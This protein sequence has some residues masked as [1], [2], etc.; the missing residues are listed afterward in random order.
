MTSAWSSK[1]TL[2]KWQPAAR[3]IWTRSV[4]WSFPPFSRTRNSWR[5]LSPVAAPPLATIA[6]P[7]MG[8]ARKA[9]SDTPTSMTMTVIWGGTLEDIHVTL[10]HGIRWEADDDTRFNA[11]PRYLADGILTRD[12]VNDVTDYVLTLSG[13]A[14]ITE[15][16]TRGSEI[17]ARECTTCHMDG[18][19]GNQEL[20]APQP[21]GRHLALWRR[22]GLC[23]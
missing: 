6:H 3:S 7:A 21:C 13:T 2:L 22:P 20:G 18:G 8:L 23:L 4:L 5:W 16:A 14:E 1:T 9:L 17:F 12:Q 15:A 10:K 11:M 19:I